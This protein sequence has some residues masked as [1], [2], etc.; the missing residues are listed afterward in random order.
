MPSATRVR[1]QLGGQWVDVTA[2]A[3]TDETITI[4]RGRRSRGSEVETSKATVKLRDDGRFNWRNP[5][6]PYFGQLA[7]NTPVRIERVSDGYLKLTSADAGNYAETPDHASLDITGDLDVRADID[8]DYERA[9]GGVGVASKYTVSGNQRSWAFWVGNDGTISLRWSTNGTAIITATSTA[10]LPFPAARTRLRATLDVNNGAS[11]WTAT[12]YTAP[13]MAGPWTQL[14]APVTGSGVTSLFASTAAL[15]VGDIPSIS[16]HH[17]HGRIYALQVRNG[18]GSTIVAD[19]DPSA[20]TPNTTSL[21]DSAGRTWTLGAGAR[22]DT[23]DIRFCGLLQKLPNLWG[24]SGRD[25]WALA[26]ASGLISNLEDDQAPLRSPLFRE[27]T[28]AANLDSLLVYY[29]AE[30]GSQ[31]TSLASGIGGSAMQIKGDIDLA[32]RADILGSEPLPELKAG[33]ILT[34][35]IPWYAV[36]PAPVIAFRGVFAVPTGGWADSARIAEIRQ[37]SGTV[38]RWLLRYHS[39]GGG[40][41]ILSCYDVDDTLLNES[42]II[43]FGLNGQKG[44]IGFQMSQSGANVYWQIFFRRINADLTVSELGSDGTFNTLQVTRATRI[45][46][47]AGGTLTGGAGGHFMVGKSTTLA[48]GITQAIVGNALEPAGRRVARLCRELDITL[49]TVGDLD[50]TTPAGPQRTGKGM[51]LIRAAADVDQGVLGETRDELALL[52]R[53]RRSTYAQRTRLALTYGQLGESPGLEPDPDAADIVNDVTVKNESGSSARAVLESGALSVLPPGQGGVGRKP[54]EYPVDVGSDAQLPD[55]AA[56]RLHANTVDEERFPRISVEVDKL[57]RYG[58][59]DLAYAA[60]RMDLLDRITLS[61]LPDWMP[62][63]L[64]QHAEGMTET[65]GVKT[66]DIEFA[67]SPSRPWSNVGVYDAPTSRYDSASSRLAEVLTTTDMVWSTQADTPS[68]CWSTALVGQQVQVGGEV[69]QVT[70]VGA[71]SGSG[72]YTQTLTVTRSVNGAVMTH[73]IGDRIR[74][75]NPVVY[76][77]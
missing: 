39:L 3:K 9:T 36:D 52:Y 76:G 14:G 12:F 42:A 20:A 70:A 71:V 45:A 43:S 53:T 57:A 22:F 40:S 55:E 60:A 44:M 4:Q 66:W 63:A 47:A 31:A 25:R 50:D 6:G 72:P 38:T 61:G 35:T 74:L 32:A 21:V 73:Q 27:A 10:T 51:D 54:K 68:D 30:D 67:C 7:P 34:A 46:V 29:P 26:S 75:A 28:A 13:S 62:P 48:A 24:V 16:L 2:D 49:R 11:G 56:W 69:C 77:L 65:I 17:D 58:K 59:Q 37:A 64:D 15:L 19:L 5:R 1:L 8:L 41:L 33:T 23:G 18:I